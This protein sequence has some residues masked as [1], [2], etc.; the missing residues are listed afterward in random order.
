MVKIL[1]F[2]LM[3]YVKAI[4]DKAIQRIFQG[5]SLNW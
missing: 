2:A 3:G 5:F 4:Y 1:P